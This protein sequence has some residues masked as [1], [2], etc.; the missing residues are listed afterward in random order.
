[1][2]TLS[3]GGRPADSSSLNRKPG[4][5]WIEK[6]GGLPSYFRMVANA[7]IRKGMD[8]SRAIATAHNTIALWATG[9]NRD[10]SKVSPKVQAAAAAAIAEWNAKKASAHMSLS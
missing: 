8:A 7:L 9:V 3:P 6:A 4:T 5:N 2:N 1:M 10:G